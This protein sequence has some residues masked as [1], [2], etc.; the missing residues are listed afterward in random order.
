MNRA[1]AQRAV[2][3]MVAALLFLL[4]PGASAYGAAGRVFRSSKRAA[5]G[6]LSPRSAGRPGHR[7]SE[8]RLSV[9][10]LS[11]PERRPEVSGQLHELGQRAVELSEPSA[12]LPSETLKERSGLI[13]AESGPAVAIPASTSEPR[14]S[15]SGLPGLWGQL[16]LM[17][18]GDKEMS[19]LISPHRRAMRMAAGLKMG[20]GW[21]ALGTALLI[22]P[23]LETAVQAQGQGL[24]RAW[25]ALAVYS[26]ALVAVFLATAALDLY[27]AFLSRVISFRVVRDAR[28]RLYGTLL[29][30]S[31]SF[32]QREENSSAALAGR[33]VRDVNYLAEKNVDVRL[34]LLY[35]ASAF[36]LGL[37]FMLSSHLLMALA[38]FPALAGIGYWSARLGQ[39][40]Q[41]V[42]EKV[43]D[44]E[45]ENMRRVQELF[46]Q[47]AT[48]KA[49]H[50]ADKEAARY[51]READGLR[52]LQETEARIS[53]IG[54]LLENIAA[55]LTRD[56]IFLAGGLLAA[57][58]R[59]LS[60]G[61]LAQ[62]SFFAEM[63]IETFT[64]FAER[65]LMFKKASGA[66]RV[67]LDLIGLGSGGGQEKPGLP[68]AA[69]RGGVRFE[70][71][72]F[73][74]RRAGRETAVLKGLS[75][76]AAA[77]E[78]IGIVGKSGSGKST[79]A[80]L[81][82]GLWEPDSGVISIDGM[83]A[84]AMDRRFLLGQMAFVSQETRLFNRT[85]GENLTYGSAGVTEERLLDAIRMASADFVLD[86]KRFPK[87]LQTVIAEG[88]ST[89]SGGERQR[90]ALV[91]AMLRDPRILVLDEPT[92]ALDPVT[93]QAIRAALKTLVWRGARPTL[94]LITHRLA[95]AKEADKIVLLSEGRAAEIGTHEQLLAKSDG[96]YAQL[97]NA[98]EEKGAQAVAELAAAEPVE[99]QPRLKE[100]EK[101]QSLPVVRRPA[102]P[103]RGRWAKAWARGALWVRKTGRELRNFVSGDPT[104][105]T[106]LREHRSR[107]LVIAILLVLGAAA[108]PA[109]CLLLGEFT[110]LAWGGITGLPLLKLA[111]AVI[112][113]SA[114]E[115]LAERWAS[116]WTGTIRARLVKDLRVDLLSK[117]LK[118]EMSFHLKKGSGARAARLGGDLDNVAAKNVSLRLPLLSHGLSLAFCASLM[119]S[120]SWPMTLLILVLVPALGVTAGY[121]GEESERIYA[122]YYDKRSELGQAAQEGLE[123]SKT[124]RLAGQ[125][126]FE[127]RRFMRRASALARIGALESWINALAYVLDHLAT[128]FVTKVLLFIVGAWAM[129]FGLSIGDITA[130]AALAGYIKADFDAASSSWIEYKKDQ[131]S[132][133]VVRRWQT[134]P[135]RIGDAP[136]AR[137]I[138]QPV[139]GEVRFEG[140]TFGYSDQAGPPVLEGVTFTAKAGELVALVGRSGS[141]K[142]TVLNLVRRLWEPQAGRILIDGQD[143]RELTLESHSRVVSV[144]PQENL[145]F[146]DSLERNLRYGSENLPEE[147]FRAAIKAGE[148][149]FAF[150]KGLHSPVGE[151][152]E[153]LSGGQKQRVAIVRAIQRDPKVLLLDEPTASQDRGTEQALMRTLYQISKGRTV[154]LVTHNLAMARRA[155]RIVVFD[156]GHVAESGTHRDLLKRGGVYR[157]LW[158]ARK[159]EPGTN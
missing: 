24:E 64:G 17:V 22:D 5:P 141:G 7:S 86:P 151:A 70:D 61:K 15:G 4:S 30:Q 77:G 42:A 8:M 147:E 27:Q 80:H 117:L 143:V 66:S 116:F 71:V 52:A 36:G 139:S 16:R 144:V 126:E 82:G 41:D 115:A 50:T 57:V 29:G 148:A 48:V 132:T 26:G 38:L 102:G 40:L 31:P 78:T 95:S 60:F 133:R 74:Y 13:D 23:L 12:E 3:A 97:W 94:L 137:D 73:S 81:L 121:L 2:A 113:F 100:A 104:V 47:V 112:V 14:S 9:S 142:S 153:L 140:V 98:E 58:G 154:L 53:S 134:Q 129:A 88:G 120:L 45:S 51:G 20:V 37:G 25:P 122:R 21:G 103:A 84:R 145:L 34:P 87:G 111:A 138:A 11:E 114:V 35:F 54:E 63:V 72:S 89:L 67:A 110:D 43:S 79:I 152:G 6:F 76:E 156:R 99:P 159:K 155:D 158:E 118:R 127:T 135:S 39:K 149:G 91:R 28:V 130:L 33:I 69:I 62:F 44:R 92:S 109:A 65:F 19:S 85:L 105:K 10:S 107:M 106:F 46:Q 96:L 119:L 146:N 157:E 123:H 101:R 150:S 93:D 128:S 124:I 90:I 55:F 56:L 1:K 83:D 68:R 49:F 18:A 125:E 59:G 136:G 131:G 75:F 108:G 32:H